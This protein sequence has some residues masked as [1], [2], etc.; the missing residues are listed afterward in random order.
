M[1]DKLVLIAGPCVI[2]DY[3]TCAQVAEVV[4]NLQAQHGDNLH[5]IFKSSFDKANRTSIASYRGPGVNEGIGILGAIKGEFNMPITTDFHTIEQVYQYGALFDVIQIP[6]LLSRQTDLIASAAMV[7]SIVNVKKGQYMKPADAMGIHE[8][9]KAARPD[10]ELW[11]TERGTCFGYGR[12]VV[13]FTGFD[14][15]RPHADRLIM[16]CTHSNNGK[17]SDTATLA[18]CAIAAGAD[19]LFVECHPNPDQAKCDGPNSMD[20]IE[21]GPLVGDIL[22]HLHGF[23]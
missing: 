12:L 15:M 1:R 13:D 5:C 7:G 11:I 17:R 14:I 21:L 10:C 3:E 18:K 19:G 23:I 20:L 4:A 9:A 8:K 2:E 22:N 16:D 6:A